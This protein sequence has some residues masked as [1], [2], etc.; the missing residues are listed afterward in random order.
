MAEYPS[1]RP[2]GITEDELGED[3]GHEL[4]A[5]ATSVPWIDAHQ[6]TQTLSWDEQHEFDL[7][8]CQA[9]VMIAANY[10]WSPYR[11]VQPDD[12]R[13]L[14]D[15]AIKWA[16]YLNQK[17]LY[18]QYVAIGIHTVGRVEDAEELLGVLPEY[19]ALDEVVAIGETGIEPVQYASRWPL[20]EQKRVVREQ[21]RIAEET[22]T[23]LVLHTPT[24]KAGADTSS[25]Q[26]WGGLGL[27][28]PLPE[29]DYSQP[30]IECT[31]IDVELKDEA[32]LADERLLVDHGDPSVVEFV[33][34]ST[35]CYLGFSV[36]S[37]LKGVTSEDIADVVHEYGP[38]RVILD[39]D[40]MGYRHSDERCI[41][42][43]LGDLH[44]LGVGVDALRQIAFENPRDLLGLDH[45]E[46]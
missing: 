28:A 1:K 25:E 45:I 9:A 13:F 4:S 26:G 39:S 40:A 29:I 27:S 10:H 12:V 33:M 32:G 43:T 31:E 35:D 6:H 15:L 22:E 30:K 7:T 18:E 3:D 11:P 38:D 21:M 44:R 36:S 46:A 34:E 42:E 24:R 17:H 37:P 20:A 2:I 16:D 8:G 5:A 19:A 23:P 14:W 41:A